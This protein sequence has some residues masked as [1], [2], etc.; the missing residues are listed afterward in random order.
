[1]ADRARSAMM[2]PKIQAFVAT[3]RRFEAKHPR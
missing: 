2:M 3:F 1:M